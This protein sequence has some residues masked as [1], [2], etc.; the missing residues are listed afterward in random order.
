M[1]ATPSRTVC[2]SKD[3]L[4]DDSFE[5]G[6]HD[7]EVE[8][9]T[10]EPSEINSTGM[11]ESFIEFQM[12][13][14]PEEEE[15]TSVAPPD[16]CNVATQLEKETFLQNIIDAVGSRFPELVFTT[17]YHAPDNNPILTITQKS[18]FSHLPF[19]S[20]SRVNITIQYKRYSVY[21]LMRLW[22]EG[23]IRSV[24]D[25]VELC[26]IFGCKSDYKFCPGVD[27]DHYEN[28][29]YKAIRFHI[30]S[31]RL[32]QFPFPRVDSV[33][34]KL[35]FLP[36]SNTSA[37]EKAANEVKCPACKRMVQ[38]LKL[39]KKRKLA[40][41]PAKRIKRQLPSSR[42]RLKHMSP[43]SQQ[44]CKRYAQYQRSSSNRKLARLEQNEVTLDSDQN[45]EMCAVVEA[46]PNEE[47]EKLF[48][49]G[50]QHGVGS[51]MKSVWFTDKDRQRKEFTQDQDR[52]SK[53]CTA[54]A[55]YYLLCCRN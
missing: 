37:A 26:R 24:D 48:K 27:P 36:A 31:V 41:S 13:I 10:V 55:C 4:F 9:D 8:M 18:L 35:W 51:L 7:V 32:T 14:V 22:G 39:Q 15:E 28:E 50:E 17:G 19:G 53:G 21:V 16:P 44:A 5:E 47:L 25:V 52:N 43:A 6:N 49:E 54:C 38:Y 11:S 2:P 34:C 40:E 1:D 42:A 3:W 29:Y 12:N 20:T 46:V 30:K 33:N 45:E 23:E